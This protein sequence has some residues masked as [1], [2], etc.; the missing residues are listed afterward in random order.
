L[1]TVKA[2]GGFASLEQSRVAVATPTF[3]PGAVPPGLLSR[4]GTAAGCHRGHR[5]GPGPGRM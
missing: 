1:T 4:G 3:R 5:G 2:V